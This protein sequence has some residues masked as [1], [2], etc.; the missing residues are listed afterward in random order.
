M[1]NAPCSCTGNW[2]TNH[3][4]SCCYYCKKCDTYTQR[5]IQITCES[6]ENT[7]MEFDPDSSNCYGSM[8]FIPI[9]RNKIEQEEKYIREFRSDRNCKQVQSK[10]KTFF[11]QTK[12]FL[13]IE[14]DDLTKEDE[15]KLLKMSKMF[16]LPKSS[17][18]EHATKN[19]YQMTS[20][21]SNVTKK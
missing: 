5:Y 8:R 18:S 7:L 20:S 14:G 11:R 6:C 21:F 10:E 13:C 15:E 9:K 1:N 19:G 3:C 12:S 4:K 17:L 2:L 16:A